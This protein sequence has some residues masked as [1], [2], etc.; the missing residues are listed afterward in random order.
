MGFVI[1]NKE[2]DKRKNLNT[3]FIKNMSLN[4]VYLVP[5]RVRFRKSKLNEKGGDL[6]A[7]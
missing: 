5:N 4:K 6:Q 7:L 2:T 1:C 3:F